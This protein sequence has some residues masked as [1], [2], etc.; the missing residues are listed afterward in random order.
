MLRVHFQK[1]AGGA[2]LTKAGELWT[3]PITHQPPLLRDPPP[4]SSTTPSQNNNSAALRGVSIVSTNIS[5]VPILFATHVVFT[6]K[7]AKRH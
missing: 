4:E 7:R 6:P 2:P 1:P 5:T 3:L